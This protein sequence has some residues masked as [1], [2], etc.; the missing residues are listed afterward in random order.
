VSAERTAS[1]DIPIA[2]TVDE[3]FS[4]RDSGHRAPLKE[5]IVKKP[6]RTRVMR[7][8]RDL[9]QL[10]RRAK[11]LPEAFRA[12]DAAAAAEVAV[13]FDC[14]DRATFALHDAQLVLARAYGFQTWPNLFGGALRRSSNSG[15][16]MAGFARLGSS[17]NPGRINSSPSRVLKQSWDLRTSRGERE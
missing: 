9:D 4:A 16:S 1:P 10:K 15:P 6:V 12:E 11:E 5:L 14:S 7:E 2:R 17:P 13:H 8:H 3:H